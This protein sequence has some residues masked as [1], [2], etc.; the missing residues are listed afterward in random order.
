ML[1]S[2]SAKHFRGLW[3]K[4]QWVLLF[5]MLKC[6]LLVFFTRHRWSPRNNEDFCTSGSWCHAHS[7]N[8]TTVSSA[9]WP[10]LS[11]CVK[12]RERDSISFID[13]HTL[14][15]RLGKNLLCRRFASRDFPH[16]FYYVKADSGDKLHI[17]LLFLQKCPVYILFRKSDVIL[18]FSDKQSHLVIEYVTI[19]YEP[20]SHLPHTYSF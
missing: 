3:L 8:I 13:I 16:V 15:P 18:S 10:T 20:C 12:E 1:Y 17:K 19:A 4:S 14:W 9:V 7:R 2:L 5:N 11:G 6:D